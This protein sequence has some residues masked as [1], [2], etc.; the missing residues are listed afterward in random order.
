MSLEDLPGGLRAEIDLDLTPNAKKEEA[1]GGSA[2]VS[3]G[4]GPPGRLDLRYSTI[5]TVSACVW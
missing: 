5:T 4:L 1:E 3:D 2:A